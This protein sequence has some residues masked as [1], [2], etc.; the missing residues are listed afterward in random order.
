MA[1]ACIAKCCLE[2]LEVPANGAA[3]E[4]KLPETSA[5]LGSSKSTAT[6]ERL[7][8]APGTSAGSAH[9]S[10]PLGKVTFATL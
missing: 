4:G 8:K 5:V 1:C 3:V 6:K 7:E 9:S 2:V 10:T